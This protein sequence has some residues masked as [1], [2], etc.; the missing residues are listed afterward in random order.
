MVIV[1]VIRCCSSDRCE[2]PN[3]P[4]KLRRACAAAI[5]P[6]TSRA[7]SASAGC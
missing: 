3:A 6:L 1:A 5:P 2:L 7:P 4:A